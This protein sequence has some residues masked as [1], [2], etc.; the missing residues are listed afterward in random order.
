MLEKTP[1]NISSGNIVTGNMDTLGG[2]CFVVVVVVA[3]VL[4][5]YFFPGAVKQIKT[6]KQSGNYPFSAVG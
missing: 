2:D 6:K 5:S 1:E 4:F 3:V